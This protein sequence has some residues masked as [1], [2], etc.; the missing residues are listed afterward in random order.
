MKA[1]Y[2]KGKCI[3][4]TFDLNA[5]AEL[6]FA[7]LFLYGA[8]DKSKPLG[9]VG[10][11]LRAMLFALQQDVLRHNEEIDESKDYALCIECAQEIDLRLLKHKA[12]PDG[13]GNLVHLMCPPFRLPRKE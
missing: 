10:S 2:S 3:Y 7:Y 6:N 11:K 5:D 4:F 9:E 8:L 13:T 12:V 1:K